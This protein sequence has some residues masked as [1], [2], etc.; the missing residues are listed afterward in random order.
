[1]IHEVKHKEVNPTGKQKIVI[2]AFDLYSKEVGGRR[3]QYILKSNLTNF[4]LM[5]HQ[6][7]TRDHNLV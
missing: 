5:V 3:K 1:M 6:N 2:P 4:D 7:T